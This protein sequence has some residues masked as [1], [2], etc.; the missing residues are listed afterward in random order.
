[1]KIRKKETAGFQKMISDCLFFGQRKESFQES[2]LRSASFWAA[3]TPALPIPTVTT[4]FFHSPYSMVSETMPKAIPPEAPRPIPLMI[5]NR[6]SRGR[7][8]P[9][10]PVP[11]KPMIMANRPT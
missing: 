2:F 11:A 9:Q 5:L 6:I 10:S 1:M 7:L 8:V 3:L 4:P